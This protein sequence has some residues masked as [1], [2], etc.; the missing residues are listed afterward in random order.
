MAGATTVSIYFL[1]FL[2]GIHVKKHTH[3]QVVVFQHISEARGKLE[4]VYIVLICYIT[5]HTSFTCIVSPLKQNLPSSIPPPSMH[6]FPPHLH[7]LLRSPTL[8]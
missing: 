6:L 3:S 5:P 7:Q 1:F 4:Y 8:T 2:T